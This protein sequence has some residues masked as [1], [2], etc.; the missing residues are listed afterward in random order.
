M[1][2]P[3]TYVWASC[4]DH[5]AAEP[6]LA[7]VGPQQ[8]QLTSQGDRSFSP[9]HAPCDDALLR[10]TPTAQLKSLEWLSVEDNQLSTLPTELSQLTRLE[11]LSVYNNVNLTSLP[12]CMF[13]FK[14]LRCFRANQFFL[15]PKELLTG[16][17][18]RPRGS[19]R[20][21]SSQSCCHLTRTH[22]HPSVPRGKAGLR[23]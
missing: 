6:G 8:V 7:L 3:H 10:M 1:G 20:C 2:S 11:Y 23:C 13:S 14:N 22:T 5:E 4:R 21:G 17:H 12:L 16:T 18:A 19:A 15:V 9:S